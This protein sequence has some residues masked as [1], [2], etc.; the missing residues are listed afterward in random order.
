MKV[1]LSDEAIED[2]RA[3]ADWYIDQECALIADVR[4]IQ[5]PTAL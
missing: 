5:V 2:A 1:S 4:N 3:A